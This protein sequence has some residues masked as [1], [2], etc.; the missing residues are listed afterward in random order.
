MQTNDYQANTGP[1]N[2][3]QVSAELKTRLRTPLLILCDGAIVNLALL[4]PLGLRIYESGDVDRYLSAYLHLAPWMTLFFLAIFYSFKIY[5]RIWSFAS[6]GELFAVFQAVTLGSL[7]TIAISFFSHTWL[8]RTIAVTHWALAVLLMGGSRL[9]WRY[10]AERLKTNG[11]KPAGRALIIGA[12]AGGVLVARELKGDKSSFVPVGFIDDDPRKNNAHVLGLPVL[13]ARKDIPEVVTRHKIN[14]LVIAMPSIGASTVRDIVNICRTTPAELR[15]LPGVYQIID[16]QVS[17]NH[18]RP[19]QLED[20]LRRE[21]VRV[22]LEEITGYLHHHTVLVTGAGGSIGAEMCRQAAAAK[23]AKLILLDHSENNIHRIWLELKDKFP[24]VPLALEIADVRDR[25]RM[26]NLFEK[27]RPET[28]F[29]AAAHKHV[30]LMELQPYEAVRTNVFGTRNVALAAGRHGTRIFVMISTD[31]AVNPS[32]VMGATKRLAE[33][34]IEEQNR[35]ENT[36]FTAVR[37]GNVL[38]SNGSVVPV[39]RRQIANGGPVTVT[40]PEMKRYFMTIPEAVQL[41][42]QAGA[43][44]WGGEVFVLDMGEPVKIVDLARDMIKLSGLE[45]EKDIQIE[46]TGIR[47]GEKLFEELLTAE[48]GSTATEHKRIFTA[49]PALVEVTA[50]EEELLNLSRKGLHCSAEDIFSALGAIIPRFR[51]YRKVD[52]G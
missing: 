51:S 14:M 6:M 42:I 24:C 19:V 8:P 34:I 35:V 26:E 21:P 31:K 22:N 28:V 10:I 33:L 49:R 13:G 5:N 39:F 3:H 7:A 15:I 16:G 4:I 44:A 41:V 36:V 32:S 37:F 40:H 43:M 1:K 38:G 48:E 46:F 25:A 29:H 2:L 30:P 18:L 50:L 27:H 9:A 23:P 45:P 52:A 47:P 20:L 12:G 11:N 17:V